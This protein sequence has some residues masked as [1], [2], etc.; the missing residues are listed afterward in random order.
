MASAIAG[1]FFYF[2]KAMQSLI[3]VLALASF[4]VSGAVVG[5]G[6]YI[7][8]NKEVIINNVKAQVMA[9]ITGGLTP[10]LPAAMPIDLPTGGDVS[11][12]TPASLPV[13]PKF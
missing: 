2:S 3:N 8:T 10:E 4:V 13:M 6:Y 5:G 9:E 12:E 7:F 1:V 11:T